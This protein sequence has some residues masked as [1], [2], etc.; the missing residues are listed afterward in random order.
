MQIR[1]LGLFEYADMMLDA[2]KD[3]KKAGHSVTIFSPIP[4]N[5]E[6]EHELGPKTNYIKF[7]TFVG[8]IAGFFFGIILTLGTA[9]L[10]VLPRGGRPI[11]PVTPTLLMAYETTILLGVFF[12][13]GS[14]LLFAKLPFFGKRPYDPEVNVDSFGLM[15]EEVG[16]KG[17]AEAEK[18]MKEYGANEVKRLE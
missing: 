10:Y 4:L 16:E 3:L 18:I 14:F 7:F 8:T 15:V 13:L 12:T 9:A 2:A 11:F 6:I 5:H 17:Y 1:A